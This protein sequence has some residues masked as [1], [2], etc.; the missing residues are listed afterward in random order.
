MRP[1]GCYRQLVVRRRLPWPGPWRACGPPRPAP[2]AART[3]RG[4]AAVRARPQHARAP[5]P[6]C[7]RT[8]ISVLRE[9]PVGRQLA[10]LLVGVAV[11][12]A[13]QV[14]HGLLLR[15][16]QHWESLNCS[17]AS[18][19]YLQTPAGSCE[20]WSAQSAARRQCARMQRVTSRSAGSVCLSGWYT[21]HSRRYA[22]RTSS[23][24]AC[25]V[26]VLSSAVR[27]RSVLRCGS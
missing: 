21:L 4:S 6:L 9:I 24:V 25:V 7:S 19:A 20:T 12:V 27:A 17:K 13:V 14:V 23:G 3:R 11:R 26:Q 15:V 16:L 10:R 22:A 5:P 1:C 18:A 2:A 8:A